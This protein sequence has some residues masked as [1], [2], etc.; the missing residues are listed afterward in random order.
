MVG[1]EDDHIGLILNRTERVEVSSFCVLLIP[2]FLETMQDLKARDI[3]NCI[4]V[5]RHDPNP[6]RQWLTGAHNGQLGLAVCVE[7]PFWPSCRS[8]FFFPSFLSLSLPF[9]HLNSTSTLEPPVCAT[10]ASPDSTALSRVRLVIRLKSTAHA[11]AARLAPLQ[12]GPGPPAEAEASW[13]G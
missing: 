2:V 6:D 10:F 3:Y 4:C 9:R 1:N 11:A 5:D 8:F 13:A 7:F 12:G